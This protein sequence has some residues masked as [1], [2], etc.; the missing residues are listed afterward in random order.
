MEVNYFN[1][2]VMLLQDAFNNIR[3]TMDN[4][5]FYAGYV[6]TLKLEFGD[7]SEM[8]KSAGKYFGMKYGSNY[9]SYRNGKMLY[10]SLLENLPM[11]GINK[12]VCF[13]FYKNP[14]SADEIA[15]LLAFLAIKSI[16]GKKSH[17]KSTN[18]FLMARM[19]GYASIKQL[20]P[21][22]PK[23]WDKYNSNEKMVLMQKVLPEPLA[24]YATRRKLDKIKFELQANWNVNYFAYYTRG[25]YI[26][27][28]KTFDLNK[29]VLE[30]EK[31]RK[32][33]RQ[34]QLKQKKVDA[35]RNALNKLRDP[36]DL[37]F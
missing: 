1:F 30:A 34:K 15:V 19:G 20:L 8:M 4:I 12:D 18:D 5:M 29:L 28:D 21:S 24:Q 16:I 3:K 6:H 7:E 33:T 31:R 14:K 27:I 11:T 35:R 37:D 26:S 17:I 32:S 9:E 23:S 25:F 13:D 2:P 36:N 10:D 22:L